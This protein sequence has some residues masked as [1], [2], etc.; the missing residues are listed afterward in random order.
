MGFPMYDV[1]GTS[2][3]AD[4]GWEGPKVDIDVVLWP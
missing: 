3:P 4:V 2:I 1:V